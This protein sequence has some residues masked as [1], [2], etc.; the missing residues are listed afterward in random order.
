MIYKVQKREGV[1]TVAS[2]ETLL[3]FES[4]GHAIDAAQGAAEVI[5]RSRRQLNQFA[6]LSEMSAGLVSYRIDEHRHQASI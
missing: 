1:W 2:Q 3:S 5:R 4:Y 6:Y